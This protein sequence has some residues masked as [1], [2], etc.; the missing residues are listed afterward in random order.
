MKKIFAIA[1]MA[2]SLLAAGCS[3]KSDTEITWL[4]D[5]VSGQ[6]LKLFPDADSALTASLG[7]KDSIPSSMSAFLVRKDGKLLL[8]DTG[9]GLPDSGIRRG[10]DLLGVA[11][12]D[13][14]YLF[15]THFHGDHI[16]GMLDTDGNPVYPNAQVYVS[17]AEL[18]A[19]T[20]MPADR[21]VQAIKTV[22]AYRDRLH[23]FGFGDTLPCGVEALDAAGHTPGHTAFL[24]K[25]ILVWGDI[26]HGL[27]LQLEHP[28][29][30][31]TYDMD[32]QASV[33]ARKRLIKYAKDNRLLVAGMHLPSGFLDYRT[34][35]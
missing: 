2:I 21:N 32:K 29:I 10:M 13:I 28:E 26:I 31:A 23:L 34:A 6:S 4:C 16:G 19:W 12:E 24:V 7:L 35:E 33:A 22:N 15:I 3:D 27:A 5:R 11:P 25:N 8:F 30:C 14:D 18:D 20:A 17:K 9:L 1:A